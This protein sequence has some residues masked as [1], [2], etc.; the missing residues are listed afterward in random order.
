[1]TRGLLD[2]TRYRHNYPP[3]GVYIA[4]E[5]IEAGSAVCQS[6]TSPGRIMKAQAN[7]PARMPCIGA[8]LGSRLLGQEALVVS[9]GMH[10][11]LRR[12][13]DFNPGDNIYVST[14]R[15]KFTG[16]QPAY[17]TKQ[18]CGIARDESS[19]LL[20]CI[21]PQVPV[22]VGYITRG[23]H[24]IKPGDGTD[25]VKFAYEG[26]PDEFTVW[27]HG[28]LWVEFDLS[29]LVADAEITVTGRLYHKIDGENLKPIDIK[30]WH[31]KTDA[32][33]NVHMTLCGAVTAGKTI[34]LSLQ[35]SKAVGADRV[36]KHV[37]IQDT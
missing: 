20:Y 34:Q 13:K 10:P 24:T 27:H 6:R 16:E 28:F 8:I 23:N 37:F 19:A 5:D 30:R 32:I 14:E 2:G 17:G 31:C 3:L 15:G 4:G 18:I 9:S 25:E 11:R 22:S 26:A 7:D 33:D 35:C 36:V 29:N 1:M 21:P 12:V